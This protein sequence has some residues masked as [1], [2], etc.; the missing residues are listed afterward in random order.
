MVAD[1]QRR[2]Q[3]LALDFLS[4]RKIWLLVYAETDSLS[5]EMQGFFQRMAE[6]GLARAGK[7][8]QPDGRSAMAVLQFTARARHSGSMAYYVGRRVIV[9]NFFTLIK[10]S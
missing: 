1:Q 5:G 4:Y 10:L 2:E 9:F 7:P 8:G 6:R 3:F